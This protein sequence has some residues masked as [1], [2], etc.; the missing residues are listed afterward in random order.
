MQIRTESPDHATV[1]SPS[2]TVQQFH[3]NTVSQAEQWTEQLRS[4]PDELANIEQE[5]D[6]YYR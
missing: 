2:A 3:Q 4:N 6:V 5:I 1:S